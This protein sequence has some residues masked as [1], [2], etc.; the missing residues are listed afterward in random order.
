MAKQWKALTANPENPSLILR[1]MRWKENGMASCPDLQTDT[2]TTSCLEKKSKL[3]VPSTS[4][5]QKEESPDR[6][7]HP[8]EAGAG[9]AFAALQRTLVRFPAPLK[10]HSQP[11]VMNSSIGGPRGCC[12]H[13]HPPTHTL[14]SPTSLYAAWYPVLAARFPQATV[15]TQP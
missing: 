15:S 11:P 5:P 3:F 1:L 14:S 6:G 2:H 13:V 4:D 9:R 12:I 7:L 8:Q 10:D